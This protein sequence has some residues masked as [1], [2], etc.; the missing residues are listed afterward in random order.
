LIRSFIVSGGILLLLTA[1]AKLGRASGSGLGVLLLW[2]GQRRRAQQD[3]E[4]SRE[5]MAK[6]AGEFAFRWNHRAITDGAR[7]VKAV[8]S[9]EGKRL[10]YRQCV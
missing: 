9:T 5:H 4:R 10:T 3:A 6:Y 7:M 1:M 2:L 8:E